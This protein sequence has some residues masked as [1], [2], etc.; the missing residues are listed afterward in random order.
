MIGNMLYSLGYLSKDPRISPQ[1]FEPSPQSLRETIEQY[2]GEF[3]IVQDVSQLGPLYVSMSSSSTFVSSS[4]T[5]VYFFVLESKLNFLKR[6]NQ[7]RTI[8]EQSEATLVFMDTND[9]IQK[10]I[11][12]NPFLS[13]VPS[14]YYT[15]LSFPANHFLSYAP[16]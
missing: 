6:D 3:L 16:Y 9:K 11:S 14:P 8:F 4:S 10:F 12:A 2:P 1:L 15:S 5:F 7:L 13:C